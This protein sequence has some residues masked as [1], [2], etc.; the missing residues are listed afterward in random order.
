MKNKWSQNWGLK[1]GSFLFAAALWLI[2]T[3]IND[4]VTTL[5]IHNVPVEL[6]NEQL[7]TDSGQVYEYLDDTDV[8]DV[9][10][11]R[12]KGSIINSLGDSNVIAVADV[13]DLTSLNTIPI[14][15]STNKYNDNL[16][17]ITGNIESVKLS[18][19]NKISKTLPIRT[20]TVGTVKDG[21]I[22]GEST[23]EQNLIE[24]SGPESVISQV[25]RASATVNVS[26]FTNNIGTDSEIRLYDE[27]DKMITAGNINKSISK[28]RVTVEILE[29][30]TVPIQW[31]VMGTP[32]RGYQA[33]GEITATR[34]NVVIAG[35]S[36]L[37]ANIESIEIPESALDITDAEE[38]L[39]KIVDLKEY[40]PDGV[41]LAEEDF[42]GRVR[43]NVVVE[44]VAER[45]VTMLINRIQI[46][47]VPEGF[48]AELAEE[49]A[50]YQLTLTGLQQNLDALE[51]NTI[52]ATADIA[53]FMESEG[54]EVMEE[55]EYLIP[56]TYQLSENV[57]VKAV[58]QVHVNITEI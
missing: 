4:P 43:V 29:M 8:I 39:E 55:G 37:I 10:T 17:S 21:Y 11:I 47:N 53:A 31:N 28:V 22:I 15:L 40:L 5:R 16:E 58:V 30:K 24:I 2:V 6:Q 20:N 41:I 34:N 54:M 45:T 52:Q 51:V 56:L 32:A 27:N 26:G 14:R 18:I 25:R 36:K 23:L 9:V 1:L 42:Q 38:S 7:I 12:A 46:A 48:E 57:S 44:P 35:R 13:N 49:E 50:T 19:E 33:T 3:N